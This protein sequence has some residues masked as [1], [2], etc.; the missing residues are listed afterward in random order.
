MSLSQAE[1]ANRLTVPAP[2]YAG[3]TPVASNPVVAYKDDVLS[4]AECAQIVQLALGQLKRARVSLDRE[5]VVSDGR[6]GSNCWLRYEDHAI[7]KEIGERVADIVQIPLS[8]AE[9]LQVVHYAEAQEYRSH[10]DAYDLRTERGQRCCAKGGQRLVT[11]L[12]YLNTVKQGG[13]T[14]FPKLGV[15][16]E[17]KMGRL[18]V[19]QNTGKSILTAHP[20]SL[21]AGQPVIEG[22]KWACNI[23][24]RAE[25]RTTL[26]DFAKLLKASEP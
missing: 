21:H 9:S 25:P 23:W 1:R 17:P 8:H 16:V 11:G 19:F 26:I 20:D 14:A 7:V 6:S 18:V 5:S 22:E 10:Y 15:E 4:V 3:A 13:G 24:F 12:I 2:A